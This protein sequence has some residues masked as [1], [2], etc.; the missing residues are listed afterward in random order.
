MAINIVFANGH[1]RHHGNNDTCNN[2]TC[3]NSVTYSITKQLRNVYTVDPFAP[4]LLFQANPS[5]KLLMFKSPL[6]SLAKFKIVAFDRA[7]GHPANFGATY[8]SIETE[9]FGE[10]LPGGTLV[11][12][13][14]LATADI[15]GFADIDLAPIKITISEER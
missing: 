8:A 11:L 12:D 10:I 5:R 7:I 1:N 2:D 15:Y 3:N 13:N 6:T 9:L 4:S 14:I